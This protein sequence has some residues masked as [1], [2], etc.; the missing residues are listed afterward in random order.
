MSKSIYLII[1]VFSIFLPTNN[2]AR[3]L[4]DIV[5]QIIF[6]DSFP[7]PFVFFV[8]FKWPIGKVSWIAAFIYQLS[9]IIVL[10]RSNKNL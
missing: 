4:V 1:A 5:Q 8:V 6:L 3:T 10:V 2:F 9:A 7:F